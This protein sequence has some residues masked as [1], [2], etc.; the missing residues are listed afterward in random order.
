[1]TDQDAPDLLRLFEKVTRSGRQLS[2]MAHFSH[3]VELEKPVVQEAIRRI[4]MTGAN[5]RCQAPLI[6]QI[7]DDPAVWADVSH[8]QRQLLIIHE[9]VLTGLG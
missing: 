8:P 2:V 1:M 5:V 4:R 3:P 9:H 6:R 7:N